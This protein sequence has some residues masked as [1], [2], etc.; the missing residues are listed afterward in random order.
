M[1]GVERACQLAEAEMDAALFE[2]E[3]A[4]EE[5]EAARERAVCARLALTALVFERS[6]GEA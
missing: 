1:I 3:R 2:L 6:G 4:L 5:F